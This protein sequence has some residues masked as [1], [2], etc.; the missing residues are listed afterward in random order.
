MDFGASSGK[1][2]MGAFN[3]NS[4]RLYELKRFLNYPVIL[5]KGLYWNI[6]SLYN[7]IK[8]SL[9]Y[10][11]KK[12][13][14]ISS[15]GIN[16][17]AQDFG[18]IDV[19][20]NLLG[21]PRCYRDIR[22]NDGFKI[23]IN[24]YSKYELFL[25]SGII[26]SNVC[27]LFQL[28]SMKHYEISIIEN[29]DKMLFI[30]G[31]LIYFLTGNNNC[32]T[33]L[34][35]MSLMYD[36]VSKNWLYKILESFNL[37]D[38][39]PEITPLPSVVGNIIDPELIQINKTISVTNVVQHDTMSAFLTA[40]FF[41]KEKTIYI[42]LGTWLIIGAPINK[43]IKTEKVFKQGFSNE[44]GFNNNTYLCKNLTGLW[45]FQECIKEWQREGYKVDYN[46]LDGYA[47]KSNFS[48][49]IDLEN[50]MFSKPHNMSKKI[51]DFCK[52]TNQKIPTNK[53][54]IYMCIL[55]GI[56][57]KIS[58][59]VRELES[60]TNLKYDYLHIVGGGSKI[61]PLCKLIKSFTGMQVL[62]GPDEATVIG[63]ITVQMLSKNELKDIKEVKEVIRKS[64]PLTVYT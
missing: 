1:A 44:V 25:K 27:T 17:W 22:H 46:Y 41:G 3:G 36:P 48:S 14:E 13:I 5:P 19:Q 54:E 55:W 51:V 18:L 15:L 8:K 4:I 60:L 31:L 49:C 61:K 16:S 35:S 57:V 34:A 58:D 43:A 62:A 28:I 38:I 59:T 20:G 32:D 50:E 6:F 29:A 52:A 47:E 2:V 9:F 30:P 63:N 7:E 56:V 10:A 64:F 42:S 39:F 21:T 11:Y 33:S 23:A 12:S 26:P 40:S 24:K 53:E 45:I 37:P